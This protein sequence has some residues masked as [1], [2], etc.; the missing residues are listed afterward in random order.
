MPPEITAFAA[1]R[2]FHK[3][4]HNPKLSTISSEQSSLWYLVRTTYIYATKLKALFPRTADTILSGAMEVTG[5]LGS[6]TRT[7][8]FSG[9][10]KLSPTKKWDPR[11][12][13]CCYLNPKSKVALSVTPVRCRSSITSSSAHTSSQAVH[14]SQEKLERVETSI[15]KVIGLLRVEYTMCMYK[16][17]CCDS[18]MNLWV[19]NVVF[20][21]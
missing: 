16:C 11:S 12:G 14:V 18:L 1:I 6:G 5:A 7:L 21:R 15:E 13:P 10:S 4:S 8:F 2:C 17:M 20:C 19:L 9:P 3:I